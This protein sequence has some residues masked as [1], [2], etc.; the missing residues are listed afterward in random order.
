MP[1]EQAL[2]RATLGVGVPDDLARVAPR[3]EGPPPGIGTGGDDDEIS[4]A[5]VGSAPAELSLGE[6]EVG[7]KPLV[8]GPFGD[9]E[10]KV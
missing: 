5:P 1:S 7:T 4:P 8:D 6:L 2:Y 10:R 3:G 9:R